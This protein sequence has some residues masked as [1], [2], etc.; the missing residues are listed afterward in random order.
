MN[1]LLKLVLVLN[2]VLAAY[3]AQCPVGVSYKNTLWSEG[4]S[5]TS[6]TNLKTVNGY[7]W[8]DNS[9]AYTL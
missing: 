3:W 4:Y 9:W 1:S 8:N 7:V 2:L 5:Y 6:I